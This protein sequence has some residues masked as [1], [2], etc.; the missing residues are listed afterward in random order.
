M[1]GRNI[2]TESNNKQRS[3]IGISKDNPLVTPKEVAF[4]IKALEEKQVCMAVFMNVACDK[5]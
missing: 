3:I 2:P 4:E 5:V 1:P